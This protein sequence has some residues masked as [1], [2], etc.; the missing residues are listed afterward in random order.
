MDDQPTLLVKIPQA[1]EYCQMLLNFAVEK[2]LEFS[3]VD[4]M[5]MHFF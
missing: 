5:N 2:F 1:R 3:F 4:V